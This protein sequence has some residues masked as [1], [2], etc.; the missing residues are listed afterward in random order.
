M[1]KPFDFENKS[2]G[3]EFMSKSVQWYTAIYAFIWQLLF[4]SKR[5]NY[6]KHMI[7]GNFIYS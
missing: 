4:N 1:S 6:G 2:K 5:H 7:F 3:C